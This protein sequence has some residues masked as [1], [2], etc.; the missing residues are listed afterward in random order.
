MLKHKADYKHSK[1]KTRRKKNYLV[2][3]SA[4]MLLQS[5]LKHF[6]ARVGKPK[7]RIMHQLFSVVDHGSLNLLCA[8]GCWQLQPKTFKTVKAR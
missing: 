5:I 1:R 2:F 7:W 8:S 6:L 3:W 4:C